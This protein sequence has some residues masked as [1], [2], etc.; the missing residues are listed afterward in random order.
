ME[1]DPT[2]MDTVNLKERKREEGYPIDASMIDEC[3]PKDF[4]N[5]F[6]KAGSYLEPKGPAFS[7]SQFEGEHFNGGGYF[8][9]L[10]ESK[11]FLYL[12]TD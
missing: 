10:D 9:K 5:G 8:I 11:I 1:M 7:S 6:F 12:I 4:S 2:F 3:F